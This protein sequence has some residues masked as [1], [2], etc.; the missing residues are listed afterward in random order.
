MGGA[1]MIIEKLIGQILEAER[2][3]QGMALDAVQQQQGLEDELAAAIAEMQGNYARQ[4]EKRLDRIRKD[5][6]AKTQQ[7]LTSL[8]AQYEEKLRQ[9]DAIYAAEKDN[10]TDM[11]FSRI[12]AV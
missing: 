8:S 3:A 10:W 5:N 9:M 11:L 7:T 6:E 2:R 1:A 4:T 12:I